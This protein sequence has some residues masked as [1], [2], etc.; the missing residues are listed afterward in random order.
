[1]E[2]ALDELR[3]T[4]AE[5]ELEGIPVLVLANKQD[6][7]NAMTREE[8][9]KALMS[10]KSLRDRNWCVFSVC[11]T[12]GDGLYDALDW[13]TNL[14]AHN[15]AK[16]YLDKVTTSTEVKYKTDENENEKKQDGS[17]FSYF[18]DMVHSFQKL[19]FQ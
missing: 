7:P 5:S 6:L 9:N 8:I 14:M 1:M 2:E 4:V 11:A 13:L 15:K 18:T 17:K 12:S 19:L 16:R 3:R 10:D